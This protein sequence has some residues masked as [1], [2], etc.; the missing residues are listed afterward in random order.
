MAG[1]MNYNQ[2]GKKTDLRKNTVIDWK[3]ISLEICKS[4]L[5]ESSERL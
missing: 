1:Q 2:S 4:S 3:T 5:F